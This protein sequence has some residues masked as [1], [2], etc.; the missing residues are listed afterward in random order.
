MRRTRQ[1]KP[2]T[3]T[4][5]QKL[6]ESGLSFTI[7]DVKHL[8][9]S[10]YYLDWA[11]N[12]PNTELPEKETKF[13]EKAIRLFEFPPMFEK[14]IESKIF[15]HFKRKADNIRK[16]KPGGYE[17]EELNVESLSRLEG[18]NKHLGQSNY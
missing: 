5:L 14:K 4:V 17:G 11:N 10:L 2:R 1:R 3:V 6:V 9:G 12:Y 15:F 7:T 16:H 13:Q 8:N 18:E